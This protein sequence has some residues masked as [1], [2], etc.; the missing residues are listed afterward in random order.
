[1]KINASV[2]VPNYN[3]GRYLDAFIQSIVNSTVEP[4]EV[5]IVD[6]GSEDHSP[7][8]L[9]K[10]KHYRFIKVIH[11]GENQGLTAALNAALEL[12]TG[13]YVLRADPDDLL[14]PDRLEKQYNYME[15]NPE[16]DILGCNVIYV[17]T[18]TGKKINT[19]NFPLTHKSI[20]RAFRKGE[21]GIQHP[22]AFIK[23]HVYRKYRYQ[24]VFPAED[25]EI[26]SRMARDGYIFANI[27]SPLYYMR[28]HAGSATSNLK[29]KHIDDT[30]RFR[31]QIFG[32]RTTRTRKLIYYYHMFFYRKFQMSHSAAIKML[33]LVLSCC[34]YP[35]KAIRR[36][37]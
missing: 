13:Q 16:V 27:K 34:F 31:D 26:F 30:F 15:Q 17:D 35:L 5:I 7:E 18:E 19:S 11:F 8:V 14:A 12:S 37:F 36:I 22:T 23:G 6:D 2:I 1:M 20:V 28:V 29:K 25:Y 10:Y 33:Y 3:N 9:E 4:S 21:H 32:Y 24:E